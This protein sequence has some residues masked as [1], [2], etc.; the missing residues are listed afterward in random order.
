MNQA[1]RCLLH[2]IPAAATAKVVSR[3]VGLRDQASPAVAAFSSRI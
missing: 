2:Q 3:V 1:G